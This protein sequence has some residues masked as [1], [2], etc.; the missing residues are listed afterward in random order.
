M[1]ELGADLLARV[2]EKLNTKIVP[3][4]IPNVIEELR[5]LAKGRGIKAKRAGLALIFCET[6]KQ[7]DVNVKEEDVDLALIR[8][9]KAL[10]LPVL[11]SDRGLRK[12][13]RNAGVCAI[14]VNKKGEVRVEGFIP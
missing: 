9:A 6:L 8:A 4:V 14:Y 13:L 7:L 2:E 1:A 3:V 10:G 5:S 11:T 12:S